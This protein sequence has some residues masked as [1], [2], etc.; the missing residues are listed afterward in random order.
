M[1]K[2]VLIEIKFNFLPKI[3]F[4]MTF[5]CSKVVVNCKKIIHQKLILKYQ[6]IKYFN[7]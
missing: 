7:N 5:L 2:Y 6:K 1:Q 4:L 3:I